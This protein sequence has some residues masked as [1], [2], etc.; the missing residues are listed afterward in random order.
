MEVLL[1]PHQGRL[2]TII[3]NGDFKNWM[4]GIVMM[5]GIWMNSGE[6]SIDFF[7]TSTLVF[8]NANVQGMKELKNTEEG[9]SPIHSA[10]IL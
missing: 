8:L 1:W 2:L 4:I 5:M 7:R 10:F 6:I 9:I 3:I